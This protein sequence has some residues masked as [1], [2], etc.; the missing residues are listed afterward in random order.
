[1]IS[2]YE[3][4]QNSPAGRR[5]AHSLSPF[6]RTQSCYCLDFEARVA[7]MRDRSEGDAARESVFVR[8]PRRTLISGNAAGFYIFIHI[9]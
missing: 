2:F 1:M 9:S 7:V 3:S 6:R 8:H 4:P 5:S